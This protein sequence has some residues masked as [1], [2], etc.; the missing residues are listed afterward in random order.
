MLNAE[1]AM[2]DDELKA[3]EK[4]VERLEAEARRL[5]ARISEEY[6]R[7]VRTQGGYRFGVVEVEYLRSADRARAQRQAVPMRADGTDTYVMD[8]M[9]N[10]RWSRRH[11]PES[12]KKR[13]N[14]MTEVYTYEQA[15]AKAGRENIATVAATYGPATFKAAIRT[16]DVDKLLDDVNRSIKGADPRADARSWVIGTIERNEHLKKETGLRLA[17]TLL[18]LACTSPGAAGAEALRHAKQGGATI[19]YQITGGENGLAWNFRLILGDL[20]APHAPLPPTPKHPL[21]GLPGG[22]SLH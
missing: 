10:K 2:T 9:A 6:R 12:G 18:W 16:V 21:P 15:V 3:V 7:R 1:T 13:G 20:D 4:E 8:E 19:T 5:R 22:P 17:H 14:T 11:R